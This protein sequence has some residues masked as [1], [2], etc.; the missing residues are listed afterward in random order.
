MG[1]AGDGVS[2]VRGAQALSSA[3]HSSWGGGSSLGGFG[4]GGGSQPPQPPP[5]ECIVRV[6]ARPYSPADD[7]KPRRAAEPSGAAVLGG[8]VGG[9]GAGGLAAGD[10][11]SR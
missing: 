9:I 5:H 3:S 1:A 6:K 11:L 2:G 7:V 10:A 8:G 4:S